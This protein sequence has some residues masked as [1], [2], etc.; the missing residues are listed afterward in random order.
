MSET[1]I[2]EQPGTAQAPI[3]PEA[4]AFAPLEAEAPEAS[5]PRSADFDPRSA[6]SEPAEDLILA[7]E[8][9][10]PKAAEG[11][12]VTG[13]D[14]A[15]KLDALFGDEPAPKTPAGPVSMG[16]ALPELPSGTAS[17][18]AARPADEE[19]LLPEPTPDATSLATASG[20][21]PSA[22]WNESLEGNQPPPADSDLM[23]TESML[24]RG[25]AEFGKTA[26]DSAP[27]I[28]GDDIEDRLDSLFSLGDE[29]TRSGAIPRDED[30]PAAEE[31]TF[32]EP[33][34]TPGLEA[35][36]LE[37]PSFESPATPY[38]SGDADRTVMMP[39]M[40][41]SAADWQAR[42]GEE[43]KPKAPES[44]RQ[45]PGSNDTLFM[46]TE[47]V[48][49]PDE[50]P[51]SATPTGTDTVGMEMVDGADVADRLD[52]L[53]APE[54]AAAAAARAE[55]EAA[56]A[57]GE[58]TP[59]GEATLPFEDSPAVETGELPLD[60]VAL[61][62]QDPEASLPAPDLILDPPTAETVV[63]GEDIGNR[64]SEIFGDPVPLAEEAVHPSVDSA[65]R[66]AAISQS[67]PAPRPLEDEEAAPADA[68]ER[69]MPPAPAGAD[70]GK[71]TATSLAPLQDEEEGALEE[72][73]NSPQS[74]AGANVATVTLA[75]I[76]FQQ[77]LREQALQIYRQLLEREPGNDS[78][79]KRIQEIEATK[80]EAGANPGTDA[81][82]PRP[83]LKVPK[84]KK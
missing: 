24:P 52:Q 15:D 38:S 50:M 25:I 14:V 1:A 12:V 60:E 76:Y 11:E 47:Q 68:G 63:S 34:A 84:R 13:D 64:L 4:T 29:G 27:P 44:L 67:G 45:V 73:E 70:P 65:P 54:E 75:E 58:A 39:A 3:L 19:S 57:R 41:E 31:V 9:S 20:I 7:S 22:D 36:A 23:S 74:A 28:T 66:H 78:V 61:F 77:G 80:P 8:L 42:Q 37:S 10:A 21:M 59:D 69:E 6:D 46:P 51:A 16:Q 56:I 43:E 18:A 48:F 83:G 55:A 72:D 17:W 79:R 26:K 82:R 35:P 81:R 71:A 32:G 62:A 30:L 33:Q 53:F 49:A 2:T 40:R 5:D